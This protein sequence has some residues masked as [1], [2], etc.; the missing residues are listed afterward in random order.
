MKEEYTILMLSTDLLQFY[1]SLTANMII[2]TIRYIHNDT[3]K[4]VAINPRNSIEYKTV[5]SSLYLETDLKC[6]LVCTY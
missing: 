1:I 5:R 4:V 6:F 3:C 2:K